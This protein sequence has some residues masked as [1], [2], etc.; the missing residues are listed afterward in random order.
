VKLLSGLRPAIRFNTAQ[1][2]E[3]VK[4]LGKKV[5]DKLDGHSSRNRLGLGGGVLNL[6]RMRI[7][8][9][10]RNLTKKTLYVVFMFLDSGG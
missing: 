1:E 8:M 6:L 10:V 2:L 5:V 4:D 7:V 9:R 3:D